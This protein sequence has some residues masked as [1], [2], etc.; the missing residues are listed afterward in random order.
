MNLPLIGRL[1]LK[2]LIIGVLLVWFVIPMVSGLFA[3]KS[4]GQQQ[5]A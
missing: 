2:S 1:D 4:S 3:R 5:A